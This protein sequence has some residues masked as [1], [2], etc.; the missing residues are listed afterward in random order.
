M[1]VWQTLL[2]KYVVLGITHASLAADGANVEPKIDDAPVATDTTGKPL[3]R[4]AEA[5]MPPDI[6]KFVAYKT[7]QVRHGVLPENLVSAD[8]KERQVMQA[9][10]SGFRFFAFENDG[11]HACTKGRLVVNYAGENY[12][13]DTP[14]PGCIAP[15]VCTQ[16]YPRL[17]SI[18]R[19]EGTT[20]VAFTITAKG[21]V[22][23][24]K[25]TSSSGYAEL[26]EAA[27]VCV[28]TWR[29]NPAIDNGQPVAA[30]WKAEVAWKARTDAPEA[31]H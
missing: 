30:T 12:T 18:L 24:P 17:A 11:V 31:Q 16:F 29:Y 21:T 13:F 2:D 7:E 3:K 9:Y 15:H 1:P 10:M 19:H 28:Q 14:F 4:L 26:D 22:A 27:L 6:A 5:N 8:P 23:E 20:T 25:I